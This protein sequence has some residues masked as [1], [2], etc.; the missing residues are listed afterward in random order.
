MSGRRLRSSPPRDGTN[1]N[2]QSRICQSP[3]TQRCWRRAWAS[4]LDGIVVDDL[5]VGDERGAR[6]QPFEQVVREQRVLRH[7]ALERRA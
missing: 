2:S 1:G 3:R 6:V 5:D 7:A 4:T